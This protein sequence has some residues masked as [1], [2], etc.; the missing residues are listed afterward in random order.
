[1]IKDRIV[2]W[3]GR[4][5]RLEM[6]HDNYSLEFKLAKKEL[7]REA[8]LRSVPGGLVRVDARDMGTILWF[9]GDFLD[10]IGYTCLLYTSR[11]V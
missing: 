3:E 11:C 9:G 5:A 6:S 2:D 10:I 8:I 7:D 4:K 1:M